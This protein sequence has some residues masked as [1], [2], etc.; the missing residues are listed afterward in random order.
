MQAFVSVNTGLSFDPDPWL[1]GTDDRI[2]GQT[3]YPY[4]LH[5]NN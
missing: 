1:L 2:S 3:L 4:K 5:L